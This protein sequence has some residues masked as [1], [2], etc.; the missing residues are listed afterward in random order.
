MAKLRRVIKEVG[1]E[2]GQAIRGAKRFVKKNVRKPKRIAGQPPLGFALVP[3]NIGVG[4]VRDKPRMAAKNEVLFDRF[5]RP[6]SVRN[7]P[8]VRRAKRRRK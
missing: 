7:A 1:Q 3:E 4:I 5:G 8:S 2:L 6:V